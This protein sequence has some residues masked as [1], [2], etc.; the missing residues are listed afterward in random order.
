M[1][2]QL[3]IDRY[4]INEHVEQGAD[5]APKGLKLPG[6]GG[7]PCSMLTPEGVSLIVGRGGAP[8]T[9]L[10]TGLFPKT[11]SKECN[12]TKCEKNPIECAKCVPKA[13]PEAESTEVIDQ[14]LKP[15][16]YAPTSVQV[17]PMPI[18]GTVFDLFWAAAG[19]LLPWCFVLIFK[20][21]EYLAISTCVHTQSAVAR[22][23]R[24][25]FDRSLWRQVHH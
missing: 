25:Y 24:P 2:L 20:Y 6:A 12:L 9:F 10:G 14:I 8:P 15:L 3:L 21:S 17:M 22:D 18:D 5:C 11:I 1:T 7:I 23:L 4:I 13:N 19:A 16:S